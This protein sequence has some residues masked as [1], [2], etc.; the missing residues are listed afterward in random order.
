MRDVLK[1]IDFLQMNHRIVHPD[2]KAAEFLLTGEYEV[3][4]ADFGVS[5]RFDSGAACQTNTIVGTLHWMAPEVITGRAYSFLADIWSLGI[6]AVVM[7]EGS[8][9]YG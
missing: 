3:K 7:S 4:I 8:Q 5:R 6:T 2:I 9:A 1:G